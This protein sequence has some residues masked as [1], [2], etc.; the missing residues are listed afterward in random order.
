[1]SLSAGQQG[2]QRGR[3]GAVQGYTSFHKASLKKSIQN[4][5]CTRAR[6][7]WGGEKKGREQGGGRGAQAYS[8]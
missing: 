1:M 6:K 7:G 2:A 3:G 5:A 8:K 4:Q